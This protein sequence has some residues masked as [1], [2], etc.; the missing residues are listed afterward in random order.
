MMMMMMM[1]MTDATDD[2]DDG[3]YTLSLKKHFIYFTHLS[4]CA[5]LTFLHFTFLHY[6]PN[7]LKSARTGRGTDI[8]PFWLM[9]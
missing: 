5:L 7:W 3:V 4:I 8:A 9:A 6:I 2:D 1:M